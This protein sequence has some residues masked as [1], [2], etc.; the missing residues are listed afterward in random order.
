LNLANS[1]CPIIWDQ[2]TCWPE[3]SSN[4][5]VYLPCPNYVN[6]FNRKSNV[7]FLY[8]NK[9]SG[10]EKNILFKIEKAFKNCYLDAETN[11][12]KWS[13]TNFTYCLQLTELLTQ[14]IDETKIIEVSCNRN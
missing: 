14:N 13:K 7:N 5:T 12:V 4:T 10:F 11:E 1:S 8:E 9:I 2:I 6:K 3:T